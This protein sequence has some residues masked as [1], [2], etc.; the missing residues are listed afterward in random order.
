[1]P[2]SRCR[3][4][5]SL[6]A[7][8]LSLKAVPALAGEPTF[9]GEEPTSHAQSLSVGR[10][11]EGKLL[12]AKALEST[13]AIRTLPRRHVR[14]CLNWA[15]PRL[16]AALRRAAEAVRQS[17]ADAP[18]LGVGDLSKARGGPI[19]PYSRSHQSGRDA[20][21]AF[22]QLDEQGQPV[23]AEDLLSFDARGSAESG[24]RRFDA[25]RNWLLVRAL[26]QDPEVDVQWMFISRPLRQA[27]LEEA[28]KLNEPAQLLQR[29]ERVL[30]QPTDSSPHDDHFHVRIRCAPEERSAGCVG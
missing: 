24:K 17:S 16:V 13:E 18:P 25:R 29:A 30:H 2:L 3:S 15:T 10:S 20:D 5:W 21:L 22:Y 14:R 26:L 27:L 28:R 1:M 4:L 23:P 6:L 19:R 12:G 7:L 11:S 8:A 9:C